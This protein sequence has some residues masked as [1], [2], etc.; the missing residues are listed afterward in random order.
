MFP[1]IPEII[2]T[3][4][5][6]KTDLL[7]TFLFFGVSMAIIATVGMQMFGGKFGF[8]PGDEQQTNF[9]NFPMAYLSIFIVS[10]M[11]NFHCNY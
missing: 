1:R 10:S 3:A 4:F 11:L 8:L 5:G 7:N 2:K 6:N 9:D